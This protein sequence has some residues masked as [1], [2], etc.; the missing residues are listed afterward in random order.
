MLVYTGK[1][2]HLYL[3]IHMVLIGLQIKVG[4]NTIT[5]QRLVGLRIW[6]PY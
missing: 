5:V 6:A 1:N 2:W 4:A 3:L